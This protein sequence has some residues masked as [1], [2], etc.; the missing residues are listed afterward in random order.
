MKEKDLQ[1]LRD[2]MS[3]KGLNVGDEVLKELS[4]VLKGSSVKQPK[5][6]VQMYIREYTGSSKKGLKVEITQKQLE[7]QLTYA[8]LTEAQV[9]EVIAHINSNKFYLNKV[10]NCKYYM[11]DEVKKNASK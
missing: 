8:K 10:N 7:N 2:L 4:K 6:K 1:A 5:E 9:K 11:K 3:S